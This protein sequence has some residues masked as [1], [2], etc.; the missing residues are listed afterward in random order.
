MQRRDVLRAGF[1]G[2][3]A[4][5]AGGF[6]DDARAAG[7]PPEPRLRGAERDH[8][9][10]TLDLAP[11]ASPYP[12]AG[13]PWTDSTVLAFVPK[14]FRVPKSG[15]VDVVTF[16]HGHAST[17]R[18][19][20]VRHQLREQLAESK[21]NAIL[22]VPQG[23]VH[24]ASGDFGRVME[25]G[26]LARL[27]DEVRTLCTSRAAE[28][29]L[30]PEAMKGASR[31][32]RVI[33]AG[34]S[35][36]YRA[37]AAVLGSGGVD[38]R[39]AWLFD[40]LYG[41]TETFAK[42]VAGAPSKRKLVSLAIAGEPMRHNRELLG[43]L[44]A[45]GVEVAQDLPTARLSRAEMVHARAIIGQQVATHGTATFEESSLRDCLVASCLKGRGSE[46]FFEDAT[47][48]RTIARRPPRT[49]S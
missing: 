21:Q 27:L 37:S 7:G 40:A 23:P 42:W 20:I 4:A 17:A 39:E 19:A 49:R 45:K 43:L 25:R 47:A 1:A 44:Q 5:F 9:G 29:A 10:T 14:G 30:G 28:K 24:A 3:I 38:I 34:H 48:P 33:V 13:R 31:V 8:L 2:A 11:K 6:A 12:A 22:V 46:A 15:A 18:E 36:G 35:G 26:G 41:E 32:G 16:F